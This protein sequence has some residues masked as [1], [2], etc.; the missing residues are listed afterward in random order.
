[1]NENEFYHHD[2]IQMQSC[3]LLF[4][5]YCLAELYQTVETIESKQTRQWQYNDLWQEKQRK[6]HTYTINISFATHQGSLV[7]DAAFF[8][9][10]LPKTNIM[11]ESTKLWT[12]FFRRPNVS[13]WMLDLSHHPHALRQ[14]T[15]TI[16]LVDKQ[17]FSLVFQV[18]DTFKWACPFQDTSLIGCM[19]SKCTKQLMLMY[20]R[21]RNPVIG[22]EPERVNNIFLQRNTDMLTWGR[23]HTFDVHVRFWIKVERN[24][25]FRHK[26]NVSFLS[27]VHTKRGGV[28]IYDSIDIRN[29]KFRTWNELH[30]AIYLDFGFAI[31]MRVT[32][33]EEEWREG[34]GEYEWYWSLPT[35]SIH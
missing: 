34:L 27:V 25:D 14:G 29:K 2:L 12:F 18:N 11:I 7:G 30:G 35:C 5:F 31:M 19:D 20:T 10:N 17:P 4:L 26:W 9:L 24:K 32:A 22:I 16:A 6:T 15:P 13:Q 3:I 23:K 1:M 28:F 33:P 21:R 8:Y